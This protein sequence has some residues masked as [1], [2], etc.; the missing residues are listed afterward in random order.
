MALPSMCR[1]APRLADSG[2]LQVITA[3]SGS[4]A[5]RKESECGDTGVRRIAGSEGCTMLPPAAS[6][7]AVLPVGVARMRPSPCTSVTRWPSTP[8]SSFVSAVLFPRC[9]RISLRHCTSIPSRLM[10]VMLLP[11]RRC[12]TTFNRIRHTSGIVTVS[13]LWSKIRPSVLGHLSEAKG[14]RKPRDPAAKDRIGGMGPGKSEA[15]HVKVPSPPIVTIKSTERSSRSD[16]EN[17]RTPRSSAS[18]CG[19]CRSSCGSN[20]TVTPLSMS[21]AAIA[22]KAFN[23]PWSC[24]FPTIST[25]LGVPLHFITSRCVA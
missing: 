6:E 13:P 24:S 2:T 11:E 1:D 15:A 9:T 12:T 14:V 22:C 19:S 5:G 25:V 10:L 18:R 8:T 23:A 16:A 3:E 17:V 4:N 7:Y 20:T 21:Q